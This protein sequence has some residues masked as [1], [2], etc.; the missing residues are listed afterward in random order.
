MSKN[1]PNMDYVLVSFL[2]PFNTGTYTNN[3]DVNNNIYHY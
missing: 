1:I 3:S 2:L